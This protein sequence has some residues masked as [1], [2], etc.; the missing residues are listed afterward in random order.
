MLG[1]VPEEVY[2]EREV[3]LEPGDKLLFYTD[4]LVEARNEIGELFGTQRLMT[5]FA[6]HAGEASAEVLANVLKCQRGFSGSTPL[7]DDVTAAVVEVVPSEP[8]A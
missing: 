1:I 3:A 4:G 2:G 5:C 8:E 7:T 6:E